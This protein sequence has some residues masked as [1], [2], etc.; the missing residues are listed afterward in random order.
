MHKNQNNILAMFECAWYWCQFL[1]WVDFIH[2][3]TEIIIYIEY[4][5]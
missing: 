1:F 2:Y 5:T 3:F 4:E